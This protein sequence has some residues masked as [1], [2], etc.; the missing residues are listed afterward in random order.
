MPLWTIRRFVWWASRPA[1]DGIDPGE[2]AARF[3]GGLAGVLHGTRSLVL[4]D[5]DGNILP[6]HSVS[7]GLDYPSIGP[8]HA[9]LAGLGRSEYVWIDDQ[10][11]LDGFEWLA[12][13]EGILA[14]L[15]SSHAI[16]W[17]REEIARLPAGAVMLVNLSGRGDKDVETIR[18]A[19]P[20]AGDTKGGGKR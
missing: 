11:A 3:A 1:G 16:P 14:A 2:H 7:A 9:W 10:G 6:T 18:A 17:A 12:R 8:E 4:Q 15:E 19:R 20:A 13:N 5:D